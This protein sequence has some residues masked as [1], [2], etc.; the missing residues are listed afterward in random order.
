VEKPASEQSP[1]GATG[2]Y[3]EVKGHHIHAKSGFEGH[4]NYDPDK[5]FSISQE[6]MEARNWSHQDMTAAQRRLF[7]E[8]AKS[9]QQNRLEEHSRI[10]VEALKAG[11]ASEAQARQLVA[12]SLK[13]LRS[14]GVSQPTRIPWSTPK[15]S[16]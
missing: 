9:G 14:Q 6:Y 5:G 7:N 11:G 16:Q 12:E 2:A 13:H 4:V 15:T 10:A 1:G 3:G 8:L